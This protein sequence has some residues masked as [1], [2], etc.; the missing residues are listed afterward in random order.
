MSLKGNVAKDDTI[1]ASP[2]ENTDPKNVPGPIYTDQG[3]LTDEG[4]KH[5][6][7]AVSSLDPTSK[8]LD[9][10]ITSTDPSKRG[11]QRESD[12]DEALSNV[13]A[14]DNTEVMYQEPPPFE[15][16]WHFLC[17]REIRLK[18]TERGTSRKAR[19]PRCY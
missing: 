17:V 8:K 19:G 9:P 4:S 11:E 6:T 2:L 18:E 14:Q 3:S 7:S 1:H 10:A 12:Q 16:H 13:K 5:E 15:P